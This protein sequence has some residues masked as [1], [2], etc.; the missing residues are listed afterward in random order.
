MKQP[1]VSVIMSFFNAE[2][3]LEE[4]IRSVLTQNYFN[5]ELILVND[6]CTDASADIVRSFSDDR[7]RYFEQANGGVSSGRNLGLKQMRGDFFCFL[8]ADD[9][10]SKDS[11]SSRV[12]ILVEQSDCD[13]VDG[14]VLK[15]NSKLQFMITEWR[16]DFEGNPFEDLAMLTGKSF[17]GPSWMVRRREGRTY[18]FVEELTHCEDLLFYLELSKGG[19]NYKYVDK[20]ILNYRLHG[21]S[22]MSNLEG[23]ANGYR[24]VYEWMRNSDFEQLSDL[25]RKRANRIIFRSFLRAFKPIKAVTEQI[26]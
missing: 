18:R 3:F 20:V 25:F 1:L 8:D 10:L 4:S 7:I 24:T 15:M 11:L 6:G 14:V 13:F 12:Q 22:A 26:G 23:L 19:G 5:C 9:T 21:A 2:K 16:P 17:F